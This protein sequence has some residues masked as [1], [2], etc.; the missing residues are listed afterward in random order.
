MQS[1]DEDTTGQGP[2]DEDSVRMEPTGRN[3]RQT[4]SE[5]ESLESNLMF[6]HML[7]LEM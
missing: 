6:E 4:E 7:L 3:S 2:T 1:T 5:R